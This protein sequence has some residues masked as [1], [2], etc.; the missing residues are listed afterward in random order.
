MRKPDPVFNDLL[1]PTIFVSYM[2]HFSINDLSSTTFCLMRLATSNM[3]QKV[4]ILLVSND[5][6]FFRHMIL[7]TLM[8]KPLHVRSDCVDIMV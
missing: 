5:L 7:E 8:S 6:N 4:I 2:G 3:W 1:S